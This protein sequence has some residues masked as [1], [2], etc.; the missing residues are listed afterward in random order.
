MFFSEE[1]KNN[2]K[3][4]EDGKDIDQHRACKCNCF[5]QFKH[6]DLIL[7]LCFNMRITKDILQKNF[8]DHKK[9]IC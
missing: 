9:Y 1:T 7:E 5:S 3:I 8:F 6:T 4:P 2:F